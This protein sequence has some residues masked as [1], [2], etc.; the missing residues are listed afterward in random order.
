[1]GIN[2]SPVDRDNDHIKYSQL[3]KLRATNLIQKL[4]SFQPTGY[5]KTIYLKSVSTMPGE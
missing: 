3:K 2:M 1:M 5:W 4:V